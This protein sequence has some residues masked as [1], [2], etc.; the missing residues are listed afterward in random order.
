MNKQKKNSEPRYTRFRRKY[1]ENG[2]YAGK[3]KSVSTIRHY[4]PDQ[5]S[6][7]NIFLQECNEVFCLLKS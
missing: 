5:F 4:S 6:F 3:V 1:F 2:R 7:N